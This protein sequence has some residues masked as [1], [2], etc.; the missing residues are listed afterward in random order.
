M[1][2]RLS[3]NHKKSVTYNG[4]QLVLHRRVE[5]RNGNDIEPQENVYDCECCAV[6]YKACRSRHGSWDEDVEVKDLCLPEQL[7]RRRRSTRSRLRKDVSHAYLD[8]ERLERLNHDIHRG[9]CLASGVYG[10]SDRRG[11]DWTNGSFL[12]GLHRPTLHITRISRQNYGIGEATS[13]ARWHR[14]YAISNDETQVR[15]II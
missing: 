9:V 6:R 2:R 5:E 15:G 8:D 1:S 10:V 13:S 14:E 7:P 11:K 12:S 3:G 4:N